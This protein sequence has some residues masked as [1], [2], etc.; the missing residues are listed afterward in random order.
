MKSLWFKIGLGY[1][2]L[3]CISITTSVIAIYNFSRLNDSIGNV[4][5]D[6]Y[7][8][9]LAAENMVKALERQENAHF[10]MLISDIDSSYTQFNANTNGFRGWHQ[11][12]LYGK[13]TVEES[14]LL[15]SIGENYEMYVQLTDSMYTILQMRNGRNA[16]TAFKLSVL[17]PIAYQ[18]K[19]K[20]FRLFEMNQDAMTSAETRI[21]TTATEAT[22]TVI[23]VSI[24]AVILSVVASV[25]ITRNVR[26][27]AQKLTATVRKIA[28][29]HLNQKIDV[30][31]DDEIGELAA[32]FNKMTERLRAYEELN[33]HQL[34][35]EK[36]KSETIVE[37][38]ADPVILTDHEDHIILM[39]KA[40]GQML[41][42][43][44]E[45]I[46]GRRFQSVL[47]DERWAKRL[48][49]VPIDRHGHAQ[50]D[51][52]LAIERDGKKLYFRPR[53]TK[54][55]DQVNQVEGI[56]TLLQDVTRFKNLDEMKSEFLATV[57][58][59]FRTPLTSI[60][61]T[62]DILSRKVVGEVN[63]RQKELLVAAKDDCERLGKLVK[64]LLDLSKLES[65]KHPVRADRVNIAAL[66]EDSLKPLRLPFSEKRITLNT[67]IDSALPDVS[68]DRQQLSWVVTN[69]ASNALRFTDEGGTVRIDA[70][71]DSNHVRVSVSDTGKGIPPDAQETIFDKF[72]QVKDPL[73]TTPGSVGLGLAIAREVV[74]AHGGRIWVES[75]E[76]KGTTFHFTVPIQE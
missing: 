43:T 47:D 40:A 46:N 17:R 57:S 45:D 76:G 7:Q 37:S 25:R 54:I 26:T 74:E 6:S 3:V 41:G 56:V 20:C 53:Q 58:H 73:L 22:F 69:L 49:S 11:K 18:L 23:F 19:E 63:D 12:A 4:L 72:V 24:I 10:S 59:E 31:T 38:I 13:A 2:F 27:P 55:L 68:G 42:V 21:K 70:V 15:E 29:G 28:Q 62:L 5:S 60:N 50:P 65:G 61:M 1:F 36:K 71:V 32:E 33:I 51:V 48:S 67:A 34:I 52:L 64:E 30:T 66:V 39:N 44:A 16:G 35:S 8:G 75:E 9:V 14:Q